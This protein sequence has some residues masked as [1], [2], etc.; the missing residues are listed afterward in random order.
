MRGRVGDGVWID[1]GRDF[2][3]FGEMG[4]G[5]WRGFSKKAGIFGRFGLR[6][7]WGF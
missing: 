1:F 2:G 7:S 6:K 3:G 5:F 4:I